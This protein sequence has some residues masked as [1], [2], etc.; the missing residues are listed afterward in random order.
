MN[1]RAP[2]FWLAAFIAVTTACTLFGAAADARLND[3]AGVIVDASASEAFAEAD[4]SNPDQ[5]LIERKTVLVRDLVEGHLNA[6][7]DARSLF[8][9]SIAD[10]SAVDLE[11]TRLVL[12]LRNAPD[13]DASV[14]AWS[15]FESGKKE[16]RGPANRDASREIANTKLLASRFDLDRARLS[17]YVLSATA[18]NALLAAHEAA[19]LDGSVL[20]EADQR[21]HEAEVQREAALRAAEDAKSEAQR[22]VAT[23][24]VRLLA[25]ETAQTQFDS[26]LEKARQEIAA[27]REETLGLQRRAREAHDA[28]STEQS[29]DTTYDDLR[30]A[31]RGARSALSLALDAVSSSASDVPQPGPDALADPQID[32]DTTDARAERKRVET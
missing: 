5:S 3:D 13:V 11:R 19:L 18:R 27:R 26:S 1:R 20:P 2:R 30:R 6:S 10:E 32:V 8:D 4:A 22:L 31:L 15:S 9:I 24:Y 12:L 16:N 25:V 17:F 28:A 23:E 14:A 21:A 29:A 7:I